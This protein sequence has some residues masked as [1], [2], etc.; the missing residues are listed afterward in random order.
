MEGSSDCPSCNSVSE[1]MFRRKGRKIFSG[2]GR[3][4]IS[5]NLKPQNPLVF[6]RKMS[7]TA[8]IRMSEFNVVHE[9]DGILPTR[10][11]IELI[12]RTRNAG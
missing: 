7:C 9:N 12:R 4:Q 6:C 5:K 10:M 2:E 1:L 8:P 3:K 11:R